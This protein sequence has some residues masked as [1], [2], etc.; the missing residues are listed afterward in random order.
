MDR[1]TRIINLEGEVIIVLSNLNT[2]FIQLS[3]D[4]ITSKLIYIL[5]K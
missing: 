3:K 2:P 5:S 1:L 4:I